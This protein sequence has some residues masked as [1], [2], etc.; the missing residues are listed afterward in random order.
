ML[1]RIRKLFLGFIVCGILFGGLS[2]CD[3]GKKAVDEVTG[4]R[5]LKQFEK[6]KD[7][8]KA[9]EEKTKERDKAALEEENQG[10]QE[11]KE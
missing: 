1:N 2:G 7:D 3:S 9:L 8:V 6:A 11:N 5:A 10:N 4:N